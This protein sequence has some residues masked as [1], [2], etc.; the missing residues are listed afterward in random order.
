MNTF[1]TR[2]GLVSFATLKQGI[3]LFAATTAVSLLNYLFH[4]VQSRMLGPQ[5]YATLAVMVSL[6][7][8]LSAPAS[9]PQA[10]LA[11]Y[12]ARFRARGELGK[13]SRFSR[14]TLKWLALASL[15]V[16][17]LVA[18]LSHPLADF[19]QLGSITPV[20]VLSTAF[21]PT[22]LN[23][24]LNGI[25]QGLERF[26]L[27][28]LVLF[29]GALAR[30]AAGAVLVWLGWRALGGIA[31]FTVAG[32]AGLGVGLT[33]MRHMLRQPGEAHR[34]TATDV[35]RYGGSILVNGILFTTLLNL[36]VILVKHYFDPV[37]AGY[38]AAAATVGKMVF[39]IPSAVGTLMF[40][41]V[42]AQLAAGGDGGM[43]LRKSVLITLGL[44]GGMSAALFWLPNPITRILFG[45]AYAPTA[46]LVGGYGV[47]MTLFAL[48]NL[49]MLYYMSAH[50]SRFALLL[51]A[52]L[53][54]EIVGV[55]RYHQGLPQVV[56]VVGVCIGAVIVASELWLKGLTGVS[57]A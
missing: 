42:S 44:C 4:V 52:G 24:A 47:V 40:P 26:R 2:I 25:L 38:Y 27:L 13:A 29:V 45:S 35:S 1:R 55:G 15:P 54:L 9:A 51:G 49:L 23:L 6:F 7:T 8:T 33:S 56:I 30:L 19:L 31:A 3:V 22:L 17:G 10:M 32:L 46:T 34:L 39:F 50:D 37:S 48:A 18:L 53:L 41:K 36:D 14:S 43:V 20:L 28:G 16:A 5:D 11:D 57:K 21:L 12:V